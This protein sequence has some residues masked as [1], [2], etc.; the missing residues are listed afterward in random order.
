M[1]YQGAARPVEVWIPHT[2]GTP[3]EHQ[4]SQLNDEGRKQGLR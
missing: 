3:F 4:L 1:S 2:H